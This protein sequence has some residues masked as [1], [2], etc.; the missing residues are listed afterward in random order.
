MEEEHSVQLRRLSKSAFDGLRSKEMR[1]GTYASQFEDVI[2]I[3][4]RM[5][6]NGTQFRLNSQQMSED[7]ESMAHNAERDRKQLKH[8]AVQTEQRLQ[9]AERALEKAKLKYDSLAENFD[10]ARTGDKV[11]AG[12]FSLR[13]KSAAQQEEDLQRKLGIAD[14]DY[15]AKVQHAQQA[16]QE[17]ENTSRPQAVKSLLQLIQECDAGVTLQLQKFGKFLMEFLKMI[18]MNPATFNERLLLGNGLLISPLVDGDT[19]RRGLRDI[20]TQIDNDKDFHSYVNS[21]ANTVPP[22]KEIK[23]EKHPVRK[24]Y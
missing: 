22:K 5:A 3:H 12:K 8:D 15:Q 24:S 7:L 23:Y 21:Y 10:H 14:E 9:D 11:H 17:V 2:R 19:P 13:P 20:I 16:R 4:E 6:E 18:L 1:Q